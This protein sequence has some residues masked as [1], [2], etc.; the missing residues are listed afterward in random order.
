MAYVSKKDH[1]WRIDIQGFPSVVLESQNKF[2]GDSNHTAAIQVYLNTGFSDFKE[3]LD[4]AL[5]GGQ[6]AL[7]GAIPL[8]SLPPLVEAKISNWSLLFRTLVNSLCIVLSP[9]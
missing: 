7:H 1:L 3:C 4:H 9:E 2:L 5:Q 6:T 8:L